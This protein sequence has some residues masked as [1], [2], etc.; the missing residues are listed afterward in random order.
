MVK[1]EGRQETVI[2]EVTLDSRGPDE[3]EPTKTHDLEATIGFQA[4]E[5]E[6]TGPKAWD[7]QRGDDSEAVILQG[8][9][10]T[11]RSPGFATTAVGAHERI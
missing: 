4:Q 3:G 1:R 11:P 9:G 6:C 5:Q 7:W 8:P 2:R 10:A